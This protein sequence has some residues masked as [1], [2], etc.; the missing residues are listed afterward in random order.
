MIDGIYIN[1]QKNTN[2]PPKKKYHVDGNM[3]IN[4]GISWDFGVPYV[5]DKARF[6]GFLD[7]SGTTLK[8]S[9]K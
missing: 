9:Q 2:T 1:Q 8:K 6:R 7:V 3:T 5:S 4:A